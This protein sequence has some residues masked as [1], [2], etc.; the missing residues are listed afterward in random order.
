MLLE[1]ICIFNCF[2]YFHSVPSP[3]HP[4]FTG[5]IQGAPFKSNYG[6][7]K[8]KS[9]LSLA[10]NHLQSSSN[11]NTASSEACVIGLHSARQNPSP[12]TLSA[13][14]MVDQ[15]F[16]SYVPLRMAW[17]VFKNTD[18]CNLPLTNEPHMPK[19]GPRHG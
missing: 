4:C 9:S 14:S 17:E 13:F 16:S 19:G 6:M 11:A 2:C 12:S 5:S 7:L 3:C 15:C 8:L 10:S 18:A 1:Y